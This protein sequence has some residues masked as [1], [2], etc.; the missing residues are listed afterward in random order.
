VA[1]ALAAAAVVDTAAVVVAATATNFYCNRTT[2]TP[3][4]RATG[5]FSFLR[6]RQRGTH[7]RWR[8]LGRAGEADWHDLRFGR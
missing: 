1:V 7:Q 5:V 8:R 6:V 3:A 4:A 2:N